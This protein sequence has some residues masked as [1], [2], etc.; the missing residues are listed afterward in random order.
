V[1]E[2]LV[3]QISGYL[4]GQPE[5]HMSAEDLATLLQ[6]KL[7]RQTASQPNDWRTHVMQTPGIAI[8]PPL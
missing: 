7:A 4:A 2:A 5:T 3:Q 8:S 6:G 1:Q